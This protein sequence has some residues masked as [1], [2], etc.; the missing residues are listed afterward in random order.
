MKAAIKAAKDLENEHMQPMSALIYDVTDGTKKATVN[1]V[2]DTCL[3]A[4]MALT[5][6]RTNL[7]EAKVLV[8]KFKNALKKKEQEAKK[9]K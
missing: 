5:P 4:A 8:A 3:H 2:R 7:N 9:S 6:L 1:D